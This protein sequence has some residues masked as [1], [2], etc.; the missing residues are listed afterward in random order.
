MLLRPHSFLLQLIA[1]LQKDL[2][3]MG[4]QEQECSNSVGTLWPYGSAAPTQG[5]PGLWPC[6]EAAGKQVWLHRCEP[7]PQ[8]GANHQPSSIWMQK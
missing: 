6:G 4:Q 2:V 1:S 3:V 5:L 8:R 7:E